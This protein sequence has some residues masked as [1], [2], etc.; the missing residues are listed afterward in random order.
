M[1]RY[2]QFYEIYVIT[3]IIISCSTWG[4]LGPVIDHKAVHYRVEQSPS[5]VGPLSTSLTA[6]V[7][8]FAY[9]A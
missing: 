8:C 2:L 5:S 6:T 9:P 1:T 7:A 4:D 3:I